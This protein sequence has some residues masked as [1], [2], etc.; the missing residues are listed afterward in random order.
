MN[1][2]KLIQLALEYYR[3]GNLHQAEQTCRN[4]LKKQSKHFDALHVLGAIYSQLGQHDLAIKYTRKALQYNSNSSEAHYNLGTALQAK[5]QLD[6]AITYFQKALQLNPTF[7][8]AYYNLGIALQAKGQL[9]D[10]ITYFQKAL[11][12]NPDFPDAYYNLGTAFQD[13]GQFDDAVACYQKA[14]RLNPKLSDAYYNLGI[15]FQAK[16]QLD[17][18]VACYQ[19]AIQINPNLPDA[20]CNVGA[21]LQAKGHLDDAVACYQKAIQINANCIDAYINLGNT[22]QAKGH[23]DDAIAWFQKSLMLNPYNVTA[24]Y[25]LGTTLH[26]QGRQ[27]RALAAFDIALF[28]DP[29]YIEARWNRCFAHLPI[30]YPDHLSIQV[31]RTQYHK[32]LLKLRDTISQELSQDIDTAARAVGSLQPFYLTY[33]GLDDRELQHLYGNLVCQIM[34]SRYP[35]FADC[36]PLPSLSFGESI[37]VGI[38]SGF[39][40]YHSNWKIRIKGWVENLDKKRINL[41]GYHT[42]TKKDKETAIARQGFYRFVEDIYSFEDLCSIIREDNLHILIYPE[43]GMFPKTA[44]LAA[45]RLAPIQCTSWGHPDTSGFP[46]VDYYLSSDLMEPSEADD[47]YTEKLIRLPNLSVYYT[48]FDVPSVDVNRNT[49]GLRPTST[50]YLCC[51]SL[52]KYLPQYDEI[53]PHIAHQVGDCQFL[54]ISHSKSRWVTEQ[55]RSRINQAFQHFNLNADDYVVFLPFLDFEKYYAMNRLADVYLDSIDWSG[56]NTTFEALA[57][58]LPVVT[59]P[60]NLMR[61]RHSSAILTMIEVTETIATSLDEY[62]SLAV[63]L[64]Q[65]GEWRQY[66]SDK[67]SKNKHLAYRDRA[68]ITALEDFLEGEVKKRACGI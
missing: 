12:L 31:A 52:F 7:V 67:I 22:L 50:I 60:G 1:I 11:Q 43:I 28:F 54:F 10:A 49:F 59:L 32:E 30:I 47:H 51:Q 39:F 14:L 6:D 42:G 26:E 40:Y 46:T 19:K 41:Y 61:G 18:A 2:S 23:I 65:D 45:L 64:G 21:A 58:N 20:Y 15:I 66:I 16:D 33:Q 56:C 68:C 27:D 29:G 53:Y 37:R 17:D 36:P 3:A 9:D 24:Y 4:I 62:V 44:R 48:P 8:K 57:C 38:V 25:N 35:Q 63:K 13:K 34:A 55:F 5:G